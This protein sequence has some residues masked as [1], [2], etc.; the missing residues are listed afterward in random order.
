MSLRFTVH[1]NNGRF[2][3]T[4]I[5]TILFSIISL[6]FGCSF[7]IDYSKEILYLT[8]IL[9][10][11]GKAVYEECSSVEGNEVL[12]ILTFAELA[13]MSTGLIT[14]TRVTHATPGAFYSHTSSRNWENDQSAK[15]NCKDICE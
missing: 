13:G 11:N 15:E 3:F 10:L 5:N 6:R 8:G 7:I 9:G 1:C 14:N 4:K 12:S 2:E